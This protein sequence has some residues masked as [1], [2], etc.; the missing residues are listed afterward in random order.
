MKLTEGKIL[1]NIRGILFDKD[2]TLLDFNAMWLPVANELISETLRDLVRISNPGIEESMYRSI[3]ISQGKIDSRGVYAHGTA[4]DVADSFIKVL[5]NYNIDI[6]DISVFRKQVIVK[7][8]AIAKDE[9]R[10]IVPT[11]DLLAL[12]ECLK[13]QGIY[14]GVSTADTEEST[15]N[16]LKRL[17]VYECFDFIGSDNG[18]LRRKPHP[19]LIMEFCRIC[20]LEPH[21][22]AVVGDTVLDMTF[23]RN[24]KAGCAIGVLSGV[25]LEHELRKLADVVYPS[26]EYL[27]CEAEAGEKVV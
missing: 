11:T 9:K 17:G 24:G 27:M 23:A 25:G 14:I 7:Y 26:I 16:C 21:E 4:G 2:G 10:E 8:N 15:K 3:G 19:D 5:R 18:R 6:R 22:V 13:R 20:G 12:F 1:N